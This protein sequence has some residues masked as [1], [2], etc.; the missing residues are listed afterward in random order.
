M[1]AST[2]FFESDLS[3]ARE[4]IVEAF[5]ALTDREKMIIRRRKLLDQPDTLEHLGGELSLSK[6]RVRQLEAQAL[7]KMKTRLETTHGVSPRTLAAS[8]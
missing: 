8:I 5:D 7:R 3:T 1:T 2:V 4:W 6:E